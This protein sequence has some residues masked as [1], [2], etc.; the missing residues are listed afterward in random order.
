MMEGRLATTPGVAITRG[1]TPVERP[2]APPAASAITP[3]VQQSIFNIAR[4]RLHPWEYVREVLGGEPDFWQMDALIALG[5]YVQGKPDAFD[6]FCL[7]ACKGP[8]KTCLLAWVILWFMTCFEHPK[9][10]VTSVTEDNL[11]DNLWPEIST[12]LNKSPM[13]MAMFQKDAER[14]YARD[15]KE[16]WFC[17]VRTW[18]KDADKT[19]QAATLAGLHGKNTMILIDESGGIPVAVLSAAVAHHSTFDPTGKTDEMHITFQAGNPDTLDG[20]LGWA[21]TQDAKNWWIKEITGDPDDPKRA[22]RI[23]VEWAREMIE[24]YGRDNP[25]VLVNV[26]GK[27]PPI[28]SNKLLG[29]DIVRKAMEIWVPDQAWRNYNKVMALDV[30]RSTSRDRSVL[31]RRQG[32]AIFPFLKYRLADS[33]DLAGQVAF[34][35]SRWPADVIFIDSVGIGGPVADHLRAVGL[36][37]VMFNGGLPA[38]DKRFVDRRTECAWAAAQEIK[39]SGGEPAIALPNDS[40]FVSEATAPNIEWNGKGQMKLESKEKMLAR[41]VGSPDIFDAYCMTFAEAVMIKTDIPA[42]TVAAINQT[43]RGGGLVT[44]YDPFQE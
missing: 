44:E 41:G 4:W 19:K 42:S 36:P 2:A 7:K 1:P 43:G 40:E 31:A 14:M 12:W 3:E 24:T 28:G 29:P 9:I 18:P 8:G 30:A 6:K 33:N 27:F 34:E 39:G 22:P 37:V 35:F 25:W 5:D 13:L 23:S 26:F 11:K 32:A 17:S 10:L 21:C 15:H 38:R 16:T 20:C